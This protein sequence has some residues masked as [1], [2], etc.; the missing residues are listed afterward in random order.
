MAALSLLGCLAGCASHSEITAPSVQSAYELHSQAAAGLPGEPDPKDRL[1]FPGFSV[2]P[3]QGA[4]W[5]ETSAETIE[6]P[7]KTWITFWK[8]LP[9]PHPEL[10]PHTVLAAV[11]SLPAT[12]GIRRQL[13]TENARRSFMAAL[14]NRTLVGDQAAAITVEGLHVVYQKGLLDNAL[15]YDCFS[16]DVGLEGEGALQDRS[17]S[18]VMDLHSYTCLDPALGQLVETMYSQLV[19]QGDVPLDLKQE[20][21]DFLRSISFTPLGV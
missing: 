14:M 1:Q 19:P 3:P 13:T 21:E 9:E 5:A 12:P 10:G 8:M 7:W 20:G 4:G 11:R 18:F 6:D 16:Y 17:F 2:A 15:G